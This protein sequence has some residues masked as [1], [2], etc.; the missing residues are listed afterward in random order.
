MATHEERWTVDSLEED[1][2]ALERGDGTLLRLPRAL[3]PTRAREGDVLRATRE[4]GETESALRLALDPAATRRAMEASAA[5][6]RPHPTPRPDP[7]GDI[8]L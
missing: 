6:V 2:A 4:P 7:G 3:L 5:Q 1:V 8:V